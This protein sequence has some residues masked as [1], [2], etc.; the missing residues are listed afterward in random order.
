MMID[1][2]L[3]KDVDLGQ[4]ATRKANLAAIRDV[5][6]HNYG[7]LFAALVFV[8]ATV[9][10]IVTIGYMIYETVTSYY[11]FMVRKQD[12]DVTN[13]REDRLDDEVYSSRDE[14]DKY[15]RSKERDEYSSIRSRLARLKMLYK[16]YN[17]EMT[18]YAVNVLDREPDDLMDERILDRDQDDY[19][20]NDTRR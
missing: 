4:T 12:R 20:Y 2:N 3:C 6:F 15:E 17:K 13:A 8:A 18:S 14:R 19:N 7:I 11:R 1:P 16:G 10:V 9:I 5:M